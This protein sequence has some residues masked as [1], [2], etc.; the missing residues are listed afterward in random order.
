[1]PYNL[2]P[3]DHSL[4]C[5]FKPTIPSFNREQSQ[6][7]QMVLQTYDILKSFF[8]LQVLAR[9]RYSFGLRRYLRVEIRK[10]S[11]NFCRF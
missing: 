2:I 6:P 11:I 8:A 1:M 9:R 7:K 3:D 4:H 5:V 10:I